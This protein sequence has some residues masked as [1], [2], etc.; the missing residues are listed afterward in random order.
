MIINNVIKRIKGEQYQ[1]DIAIPVGYMFS[2]VVGKILSM[3]WGGG[4]INDIETH[5][6]ESVCNNQVCLKIQ[7]RQR[8]EYR[9]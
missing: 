3:L 8:T 5:F 1:I 2:L 4:K 9:I 7:V 6:F